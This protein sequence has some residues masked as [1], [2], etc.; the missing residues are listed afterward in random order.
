MPAPNG[1][2]KLSNVVKNDV[3]K[4]I[5]YNKLVTKVV[6]LILQNLLKRPNMKRMDQIFKIKSIR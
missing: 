5:E 2:A 6:T 1:L 4:K 3:V